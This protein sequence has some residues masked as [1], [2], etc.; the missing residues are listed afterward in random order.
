MKVI[1][2]VRRVILDLKIGVSKRTYWEEKEI[3]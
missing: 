3:K 1:L 2:L